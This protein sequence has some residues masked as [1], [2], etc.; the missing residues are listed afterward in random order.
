MVSGDNAEDEEVRRSPDFPLSSD[1]PLGSIFLGQRL[2]PDGIL[3][4][5]VIMETYS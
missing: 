5:I 1:I 2:I 4:I 3:I